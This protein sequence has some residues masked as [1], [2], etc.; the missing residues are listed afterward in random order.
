MGERTRRETEKRIVGVND[1]EVPPVPIPNTVV[2]LFGAE[3]TWRE[4]ARENRAMPT[5]SFFITAL[6]FR[7]RELVFHKSERENKGKRQNARR[8]RNGPLV[9]RFKTLASHAEDRSSILLRV[10]KESVP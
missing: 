2:K 1:E 9:K 6:F 8:Q 4:T 10:T 7:T 5:F 3:D